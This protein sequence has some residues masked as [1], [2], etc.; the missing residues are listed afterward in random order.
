MTAVIILSLL[1]CFVVPV[2]RCNSIFSLL[3]PPYLT[4]EDFERGKVLPIEAYR[5]NGT[6]FHEQLPSRA[7]TRANVWLAPTYKWPNARVPYV[8]SPLYN[9]QERAIIA[10]SIREWESNTCIRFVPATSN[11]RDYIELTPNDGTDNFCYSYVGRQGGRQFV[12]MYAPICMSVGQY[13]HELGHAI[14]FGHEHQRP[15]RDYYVEIKWENIDPSFYYAYDKYN[16]KDFTTLG[17]PYDY[18]SIMHYPDYSYS[19]NGKPAFVPKYP[20]HQVSNM[21]VRLTPTDIE[22]TKK[23]YN[24]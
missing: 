10:E 2:I 23:Y 18:Y 11:D 12:K 19:S 8:I 17:M 16:A 7:I 5:L 20:G 21:N 22:K 6:G 24:C 1:F 3:R 4:D 14:G 9:N 13:V 15:D